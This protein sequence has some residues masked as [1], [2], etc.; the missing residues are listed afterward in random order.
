MVGIGH[1]ALY[2]NFTG[3]S[4]VVLGNNSMFNN[5]KSTHIEGHEHNIDHIHETHTSK[6]PRLFDN[7]VI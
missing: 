2:S 5:N 6:K 3:S 1:R 4:N 7:N